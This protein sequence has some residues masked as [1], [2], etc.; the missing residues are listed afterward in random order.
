MYS[1]TRKRK[2][3]YLLNNPLSSK[4]TLGISIIVN[5]NKEKQ[6]RDFLYFLISSNQKT[7]VNFLK[8]N[9]IKQKKK[10]ELTLLIP[11]KPDDN[12]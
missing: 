10:S 4:T 5:S 8:K 9:K 6:T 12:C 11:S 3:F 7:A 1:E 2:V